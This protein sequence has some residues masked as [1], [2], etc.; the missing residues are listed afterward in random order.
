MTDNL[1][2]L[3]S[4]KH[5]KVR[6]MLHSFLE[7]Q[8]SGG[9]VLLICTVIALVVANVPALQH[10]QE[11]WYIEAG[12]SIGN[13]KIEMSVMHWINDALMAVFFFVVGLEIKREMLVGELSSVKKATLPI[14]AALGGML[15]PAAIYAIFNHGTPTSN[16]W[17]IPMATDIAFAVGVISILGKRCPSALKIFLLALAIVDD[18][19]A[20]IVLALFYPS[21][22]LN[23]VF[24]GLALVVFL[25]LILFN[26]MKVNSPYV[27]MLFGLVLWYFVFRSGIHATIAGVLLAIT[28]PSKTTIN[29][30]RFFVKVKHLL[31]KF[32]E[33]GNS[34]VEVLANPKQMEVI[35]DI[36]EEVDA[37]NPL[38]HRFESALHPI[39]HFLIIP[40]FALANAGVTLD[41]SILQMSPM[42]AVVPGIFFG[43]LLG[44]PIGITLFSYI[45]VKTRLAELP[46]G[47]PWKQIFAIGMVAGIGF[48]MS[49]FVDNLAFS[50]PVYLNMGKAAI[51]VTSFVSAICGMLAVLLT[52]KKVPSTAQKKI[53]K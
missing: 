14:F 22:E 7:S 3:T 48:T 8:T 27:Y 4:H 43:L 24:M 30:V 28:I 39:S 41:G 9:L 2:L 33:N 49:I 19:G 26:K 50:D 40:L 29:E 31:E 5:S 16:G 32:K 1:D 13:F 15:V 45:S 37:I 35:H 11:L 18:L 17:G 47:V 53:K 36:N 52:T 38:M 51:L 12:I 23:F 10:L 34:E 44:K 6:G 20:I 21:H 42:P 25:I 46:G